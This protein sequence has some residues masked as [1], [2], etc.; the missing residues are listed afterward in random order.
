[1][2]YEGSSPRGTTRE[3]RSERVVAIEGVRAAMGDECV[4]STEIVL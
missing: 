2:L 1:M 3:M 4:D